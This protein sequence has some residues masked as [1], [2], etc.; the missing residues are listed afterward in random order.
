MQKRAAAGA[1]QKG[2]HAIEAA[3]KSLEKQEL[4][5]RFRKSRKFVL[6]FLRDG[7]IT[8]RPYFRGGSLL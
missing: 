1:G 8:R 7:C 2:S 6:R 5:Q 4:T 3:V